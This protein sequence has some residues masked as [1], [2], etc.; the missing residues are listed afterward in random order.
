M[1]DPGSPPT[2]VIH[3][4][5]RCNGTAPPAVSTTTE[6]EA[7]KTEAPAGRALPSAAPASEAPGKRKM[8]RSTRRALAIIAALA[9]L[10]ALG[11]G[12]AYFLYTRNFVSTDNAQVDGN[13]IAINAPAT[14]TLIDWRGQQ[15]AQL[16]PNKLVGR[17]KLGSSGAQPQVT[18]NSPGTGT[19][20][21]NNVVA[22][23][24]VTAGTELATA[25]DLRKIYVTARIDETNIAGVQLGAPVDLSVDAYPG[26]PITGVVTEIEGAAAGEFALFPQ[27]NSTGNFQKVTQ[28][29]PVRV[30]FTNTDGTYLVPGMNVTVNIHK[31][32]QP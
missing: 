31:Q 23:Q 11:F 10:A 5:I 27:Q 29:I 17:V 21:V 16:T 19:I 12:G 18:I 28:V 22:G 32:L 6:P 30:A 7:G 26:A 2:T 15:G 3:V 14:G 20:A 9:V 25:Y 24:W 4:T 1:I 13:K 8:K